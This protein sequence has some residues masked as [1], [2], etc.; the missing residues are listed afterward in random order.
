[1]VCLS[2][3]AIELLEIGAGGGS[4][5]RTK[6]GLITVGPDSSGAE[7]GPICYGR[8][9]KMPTIT[10]ANLVLGY[11]NPS[12]FNGGAM[13]LSAGSGEAI[14]RDIG[15]PLDLGMEEAAWGIHSVA[16]ANMERAM[17]HRLDRARP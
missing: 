7:P 17:A 16:S 13:Q 2:I 1:M 4:I 12:Y 6:M 9:G 8:G 10:D 5:A 15:Q 11:L 14:E 3:T